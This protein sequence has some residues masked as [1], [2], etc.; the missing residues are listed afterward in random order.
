SALAQPAGFVPLAQKRFTYPGGIPYKVDTDVGLIR[1]DQKG[2]NICN[3]TTEGPASLCQTALF[4]SLDDFCFWAPA[5]P[6]HTVGE[7]EG[8]MIAWC[9]KAGHGARVI[10]PGTLQGVQFMKTPDYVQVSGFMDQTKINMIK[11]DAGGEMDP[12]GADRRGNPMGGIM[13]TQ[14]FNGSW[15]QIE[16]WHNFMGNDHFCLKACDPAGRDDARFCEHI[17]DTIG[18][19]GNAPSNAQRDVYESCAGENQDFPPSPRIPTSSSCS[20]FKSADIY[21][22][23][24]TVPV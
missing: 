14:S 7:I 5:E 12:H 16:Q 22:G 10:P 13:F 23:C 24:T 1:G 19:G 4:N 3:S 11:G 2:Y 8:E 17:F 20:Q 9:T 21:G 18:C 15:V 6:G